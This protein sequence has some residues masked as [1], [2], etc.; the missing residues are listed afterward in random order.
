M[1]KILTIRMRPAAPFSIGPG[2]RLGFV[3]LTRL[4]A[5]PR[6]LWG[7][8]TDAMTRSIQAGEMHFGP[9]IGPD[10][11][12]FVRVGQWIE[13]N[14]RFLP[15]VIKAVNEECAD[16]LLPWY[17]FGKGAGFL[18]HGG[19]NIDEKHAFRTEAEARRL[20]VHGKTGA[21]L[22]Y[23]SLAAEESMLH[24]TERIHPEVRMVDGSVRPVW[25]ETAALVKQD[26]ADLIKSWLVDKGAAY[27]R[28]GRDTACGDGC[29]SEIRVDETT[30]TDE[31]NMRLGLNNEQ[32]IEWIPD[33]GDGL[34]V[35]VEP[36]NRA[37][38]LPGPVLIAPHTQHPSG[39]WGDLRPHIVREYDLKKG[40][41]RRTGFTAAPRGI[42]HYGG[43]LAVKGESRFRLERDGWVLEEHDA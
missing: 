23:N 7:A 34:R 12:P 9:E 35:R 6:T 33:Q 42:L 43:L 36:T 27:L 26:Q 37:V 41:G 40:F 31:L 32:K 11:N 18:L 25:L 2:W 10:E 29:F 4:D 20:F 22:D 24:E 5:P 17:A 19:G 16:R 13:E 21:A 38:R 14:M 8:F 30:S 39:Y 1:W 15:G 3:M 28:I